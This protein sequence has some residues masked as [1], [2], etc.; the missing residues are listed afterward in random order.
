MRFK[1][2]NNW[3]ASENK[4]SFA[5]KKNSTESSSEFILNK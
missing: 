5:F 4:T 2:S 1:F 3:I